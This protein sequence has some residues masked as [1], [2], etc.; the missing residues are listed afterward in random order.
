[1][2]FLKSEFDALCLHAFGPDMPDKQRR[3]L[4][5]AFMA[6][7]HAIVNKLPQSLDPGIIETGRDLE[8]MASISDEID[9]TYAEIC[10]AC[11]TKGR[12]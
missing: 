8:I 2:T 11:E 1:M 4:R 5:W 3:D 6:G 9:E 10:A 12:A 7:A